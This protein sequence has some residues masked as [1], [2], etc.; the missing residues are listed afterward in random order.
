[1]KVGASYVKCLHKTEPWISLFLRYNTVYCLKL[2]ISIIDDL[3]NLVLIL[4]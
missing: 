1:M 3:G 2:T 4:S